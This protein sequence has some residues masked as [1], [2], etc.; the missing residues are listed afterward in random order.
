MAKERSAALV[1]VLS[2]VTLGIYWLYWYYTVNKEIV[3]VSNGS[4]KASPGVALL[5]QFIPIANIVSLYNTASRLQTAKQAASDPHTI[6]PGLCIVIALFVPFGIYSAL[7]QSG[8]NALIH[9]QSRQAPAAAP[10]ART[11]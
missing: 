3:L 11:A 1:V 8:L 7:V 10:V 4:V 5:A 9:H 6:S 2:I